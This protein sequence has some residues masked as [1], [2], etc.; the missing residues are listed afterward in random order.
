MPSL[1]VSPAKIVPN[2]CKKG[3]RNVKWW[4]MIECSTTQKEEEEKVQLTPRGRWCGPCQVWDQ[5]INPP[6]SCQKHH[7]G[8]KQWWHFFTPTQPKRTLV[9]FWGQFLLL[10]PISRSCN[11]FGWNCKIWFK[12]WNFVKIVKFGQHCEIWQKLA[13]F[14]GFVCFLWAVKVTSQ[15]ITK[16]PH[17][18]KRLQERNYIRS[19]PSQVPQPTWY[20]VGCW[21]VFWQQ[22]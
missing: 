17:L 7:K 21:I 3:Q 12:V 18:T 10:G 16:S 13:N 4:Q 8:Q 20:Y 6:C 11:V 1:T 22:G 2:A 14:V 9:F 15:F 19:F 5:S